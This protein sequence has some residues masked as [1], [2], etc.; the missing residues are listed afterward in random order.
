MVDAYQKVLKHYEI[1][2]KNTNNY[3]VKNNILIIFIFL[4]ILQQYKV[5][6][7]WL[8]DSISEFIYSFYIIR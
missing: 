8:N 4:F 2:F 7:Y 6:S 3:L 1:D 5:E